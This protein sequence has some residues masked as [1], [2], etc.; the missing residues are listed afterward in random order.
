MNFLWGSEIE[1]LLRSVYQ[2]VIH[3][4]YLSEFEPNNKVKAT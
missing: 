4:T 3:N 2:V 1:Q